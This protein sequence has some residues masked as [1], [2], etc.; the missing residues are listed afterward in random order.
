MF[1]EREFDHLCSQLGNFCIYFLFLWNLGTRSIYISYEIDST[2]TLLL[3]MSDALRDDDLYFSYRLKEKSAKE[4][5]ALDPSGLI[6]G[7]NKTCDVE[8]IIAIRNNASTRARGCQL[9][10]ILTSVLNIW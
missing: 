9:R 4:A 2:F 8:P 5:N 3:P 7:E 1:A 10:R 6:F